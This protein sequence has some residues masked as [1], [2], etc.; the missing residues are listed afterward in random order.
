MLLLDVSKSAQRSSVL[1]T[2]LS[3]LDEIVIWLQFES[4]N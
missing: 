3:H 1:E 2:E 4:V